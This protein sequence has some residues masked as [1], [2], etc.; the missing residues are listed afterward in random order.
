MFVELKHITQRKELFEIQAAKHP[1][2]KA[3]R[4]RHRERRAYTYKVVFTVL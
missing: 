4:H 1:L 2:I 3:H